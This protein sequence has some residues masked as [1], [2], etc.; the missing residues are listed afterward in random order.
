[1]IDD[2]LNTPQLVHTA[3][4]YT[5]NSPSGEYS[6]GRLKSHSYLVLGE[7]SSLNTLECSKRMY[8]RIHCL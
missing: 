5:R 1:M 2:S 8:P 7:H 4:I 3:I 6:D